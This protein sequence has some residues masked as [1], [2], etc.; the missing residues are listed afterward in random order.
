MEGDLNLSQMLGGLRIANNVDTPPASPGL[1][2]SEYSSGTD[3]RGSAHSLQQQQS[4]ATR[5]DRHS[6]DEG[7]QPTSLLR[8][9]QT[10][11]A[12][13]EYKP[14]HPLSSNLAV[15]SSRPPSIYT[16]YGVGMGGSQSMGPLSLAGAPTY[17]EYIRASRDLSRQS[18]PGQSLAHRHSTRERSDS[19]RSYRQSATTGPMTP[20]GPN[21][22]ILA[23]H[24]GSSSQYVENGPL[25]SS[26]E[27]NERGAAVAIR[28]EIDRNGN[29]TTRVVKK[30]VKDF[31]FG[32]TLGEGSY[33]TVCAPPIPWN[34]Q[35]KV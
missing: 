35:Y 10:Q 6:H 25:P 4:V 16:P 28:R 11:S 29:P 34:G 33:S 27:W 20:R 8:G 30:G 21:R 3:P 32:R 23:G 26:E 14:P 12:N 24:G 15:M 2:P 18:L 1:P 5:G 17:P 31:N 7:Q 19:D 13:S 22:G 9:V